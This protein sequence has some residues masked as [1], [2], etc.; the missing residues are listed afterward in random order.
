[1]MKNQTLLHQLLWATRRHIKLYFVEFAWNF[2][3]PM[4]VEL[5]CNR[6]SSKKRMTNGHDSNVLHSLNIFDYRVA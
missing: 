1:M 3:L 2:K 5:V 4:Q 6:V